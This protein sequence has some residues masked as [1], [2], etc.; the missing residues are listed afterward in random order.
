MTSSDS[1]LQSI[2]E[3]FEKLPARR[4]TAGRHRRADV[5]EEY[6]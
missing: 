5:K 3:T 6:Q 2:V 1:R 4:L